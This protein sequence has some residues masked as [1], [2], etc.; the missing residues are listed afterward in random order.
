VT[1]AERARRLARELTDAEIWAAALDT[2]A[3]GIGQCRI[4][5][6]RAQPVQ[7]DYYAKCADPGTDAFYG[8][9]K[10]PEGGGTGCIYSP[11]SARAGFC[12]LADTERFCT[13]SAQANAAN[14]IRDALEHDVCGTVGDV[15]DYR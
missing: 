7:C 9:P 3:P 8:W 10:N 13:G 5:D 15:A 6:G 1:N 12:T 11:D 4:E 2:N 14:H